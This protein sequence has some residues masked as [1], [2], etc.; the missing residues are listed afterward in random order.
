MKGKKLFV[1]LI[2]TTDGFVT[3]VQSDGDPTDHPTFRGRVLSVETLGEAGL[4]SV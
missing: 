3:R 4:R 1:Y 2:T